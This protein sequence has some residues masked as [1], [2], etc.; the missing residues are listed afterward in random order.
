[1]VL[2]R[3]QSKLQSD[4]EIMVRENE[5]KLQSDNEIMVRENES[6]KETIVKEFTDNMKQMIKDIEN[7]QGVSEKMQFIIQMFEYNNKF[8]EKIHFDEPTMIRLTTYIKCVYEKCR[9][10]QREHVIG[11]YDKLEYRLVCDFLQTLRN[12]QELITKIMTTFN[13]FSRVDYKINLLMKSV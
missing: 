2:T 12:S 5:S 7:K 10:F 3:S 4:N 1:M 6:K 8:L 9:E 13:K 11:K